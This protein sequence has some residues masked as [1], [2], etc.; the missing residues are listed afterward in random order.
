MMMRSAKVP[1]SIY[2]FQKYIAGFFDGVSFMV[3]KIDKR[4]AVSA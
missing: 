2:L 1:G 4:R 3:F